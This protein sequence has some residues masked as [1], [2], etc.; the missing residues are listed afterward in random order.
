VIKA[1]IFDCFGVLATE[2]WLPFKEQ[3]F[4]DDPV[5]MQ[6]ATDLIQQASAGIIS[7]EEFVKAVAELAGIPPTKVT[8]M[9]RRNVPNEPLF[10][11][12]KELKANYKIGFLSNSSS[13]WLHDIFTEEQ[14]AQ[15]D[16]IILSYETGLA[17][18]DP[19]IYELTA[20]KLGVEPEECIFVDDQE[21]YSSAAEDIGM[22]GLCYKT[23][24]QIRAD[25]EEILAK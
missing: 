16:A 5:R 6:E 10:A 20:Q 24:D 11:Y 9:L 21:W 8:S 25:L 15:F 14:I 3:Y 12:I 17:K 19:K 2:G 1:I 18:P 7:H 23:F 4:G 22:R 13:N